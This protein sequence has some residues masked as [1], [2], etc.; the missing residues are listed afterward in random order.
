MEKLSNT[1][2]SL[3]QYSF[4][5]FLQTIEISLTLTCGQPVDP[6][7]VSLIKPH[8][9]DN[10]LNKKK[11]PPKP[12][13]KNPRRR[14]SP[15]RRP[16]RPRPRRCLRQPPCR[17][18]PLSPC[19]CQMSGPTSSRCSTPPPARSPTSSPTSLLGS[20]A[21]A[22]SVSAAPSA[23]SSRQAT[24]RRA[25]PSFPLSRLL[26]LPPA[27][28]LLV[29]L[30][31]GLG[32][33]FGGGTRIGGQLELVGLGFVLAIQIRWVLLSCGGWGHCFSR[34][35]RANRDELR[36][37]IFAISLSDRGLGFGWSVGWFNRADICGL[38]EIIDSPSFGFA[39]GA[40]WF[41][42]LLTWNGSLDMQIQDHLFGLS[43]FEAKFLRFSVWLRGVSSIIFVWICTRWEFH[44]ILDLF[45]CFSSLRFGVVV[46]GKL[47]PNFSNA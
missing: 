1:D 18:A 24:P 32:G 41:L 30:S 3:G 22:A 15:R 39:G 6:D 47:K 28:L 9:Y 44:T 5:P 40:F 43:Q 27:F 38:L 35:R 34:G 29:F 12:K 21:S 36:Y 20:P 17:R 46:H 25:F 37:C 10:H 26:S 42:N 45:L 7:T 23:S 13:K 19:C 2:Y 16:P 14:S 4:T 8:F 11:T 33:G 31:S